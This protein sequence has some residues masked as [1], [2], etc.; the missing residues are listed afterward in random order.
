MSLILAIEPDRRQA[1]QISLLARERLHAE[2]VAA[3]STERAFKALGN[4][5]PDVVL[6]SP[7]LSPR[8]ESA[9]A[10]KL[11]ELGPAAAH[12]QTLTIPVLAGGPNGATRPD[13]NV[14]TRLRRGGKKKSTASVGCDPAVFAGQIAEYLERAAAERE[15]AAYE[16]GDTAVSPVETAEVVVN[17]AVEEA[18]AP[19]D[20]SRVVL[21]SEPVV[22]ASEE[23]AA[24]E[25]DPIALADAELAAAWQM[26]VA[27]LEA[28]RR[29]AVS[30]E[31]TIA[32]APAAPAE[33][34]RPATDPE[35]DEDAFLGEEI[36]IDLDGEPEAPAASDDTPAVVALEWK[37][38]DLS[39]FM[40]EL[41]PAPVAE[42]VAVSAVEP[43]VPV[44]VHHEEPK[45]ILHA[46]I[47][48]IEAPRDAFELLEAAAADI[49]ATAEPA[50][51]TPLEPIIDMPAEPVAAA[52]ELSDFDAHLR[53]FLPEPEPEPEP[54][55]VLSEQVAEPV[56]E[57][58]AAEAS[59][60][61]IQVDEIEVEEIQIDEPA[62]HLQ[63]VASAEP[64]LHEVVAEPEPEPEIEDE[65]ELTFI[66]DG[67][68]WVAA[69]APPHIV[70]PAL[71]ILTIA[72]RPLAIEAEAVLE[73]EDSALDAE[74]LAA[75]D[76]NEDH[77]N[78]DGRVVDVTMP[79]VEMSRRR[80]DAG[81]WKD[82]LEQ[83]HEQLVP[84]TVAAAPAPAPQ[85]APAPVEAPPAPAAAASGRS[86]KKEAAKAGK[87]GRRQ[88]PTTAPV[89]DEWGFFDP[90]QCGMA[91]LLAKL[92]EVSDPPREQKRGPRPV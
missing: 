81:Q 33:K 75:E 39:S 54:E 6:T 49:E 52:A 7:V 2:L 9:L 20:D 41:E 18:P 62:P 11:R 63:I 89:Q 48:A 73:A 68:P 66:L 55:P 26:D 77:G 35:G 21:M 72:D 82:A 31:D 87:R 47:D 8:E 36:V 46:A 14:L 69:L 40:A 4:R 84:P 19:I 5:V 92:D 25:L 74:P 50:A 29:N 51:E 12:V 10:D 45:A 22:P 64:I 15:I 67:E 32:T 30:E 58:V 86:S 90:Q 57:L 91:A 85:P 1:A 61:E 34:T 38:V 44:A 65:P 79:V 27:T 43:D 3:E 80:P 24:P 83:L 23:P 60:S 13:P 28:V 70:W 59:V 17:A 88:R 76:E 53:E 42:E 71:H 78:T 16:A 37:E 56:A